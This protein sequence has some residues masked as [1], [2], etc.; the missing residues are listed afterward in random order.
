MLGSGGH[1]SCA[2]MR[3]GELQCW[4]PCCRVKTRTATF[5]GTHQGRAQNRDTEQIAPTRAATRSGA[6]MISQTGSV[7]RPEQQRGDNAPFDWRLRARGGASPSSTHPRS[8]PESRARDPRPAVGGS[9]K[10]KSVARKKGKKEIGRVGKGVGAGG[11][12]GGAQGKREPKREKGAIGKDISDMRRAMRKSLAKALLT[13][14]GQV[15]KR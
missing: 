7:P 1:K 2:A 5:M 12:K 3:R 6:S 9:E 10:A 11:D 15:A 14:C 13:K 4:Q 8:A